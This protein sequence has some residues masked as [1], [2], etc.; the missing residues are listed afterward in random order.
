[1]SSSRRRNA[2][3]SENT[4]MSHERRVFI[5]KLDSVINS[6]KGLACGVVERRGLPVLHV[7]RFGSAGHAVEIGCNLLEREWWFTWDM[8]GDAIAPASALYET[9][10]VIAR[11]LER[12]AQS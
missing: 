10:H 3:T 11:Q 1:M 6:H 8:T 7:V 12:A 9:A 5:S 2:V 4:A